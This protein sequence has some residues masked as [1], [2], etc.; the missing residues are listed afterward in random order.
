MTNK[1]LGL[2]EP[3]DHFLCC[4]H[5]PLRIGTYITAGLLAI[6]WIRTVAYVLAYFGTYFDSLLLEHGVSLFIAA[7]YYFGFSILFAIA[8]F[9]GYR[10]IFLKDNTG[11]KIFWIWTLLLSVVAY[12]GASV[13]TLLF[14]NVI[15]GGYGG[16]FIGNLITLCVTG[17]VKLYLAFV[18]FSFWHFQENDA[19]KLDAPAKGAYYPIKK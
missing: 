2:V 11:A 8:L 10:G 16:S 4:I 17:L 7:L 9:F 1:F 3:H 6:D 18:L 5:V 14:D 13:V 12:A 19:G 15:I